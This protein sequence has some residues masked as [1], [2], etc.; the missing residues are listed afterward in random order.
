MQLIRGLCR[1]NLCT[2]NMR[3]EEMLAGFCS[4]LQR[5]QETQPPSQSVEKL[6]VGG[7]SRSRG[8]EQV[9]RLRHSSTA[10][11]RL[12]VQ[13]PVDPACH[14]VYRLALSSGMLECLFWNLCFAR[15]DRCRVESDLRSTPGHVAGVGVA[16]SQ[17][18]S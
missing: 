4:A 2:A 11:R 6:G 7:M 8:R 14:S 3:R 15:D 16:G 12:G 10:L 18:F 17:D 1:R 13:S 9:R 5:R